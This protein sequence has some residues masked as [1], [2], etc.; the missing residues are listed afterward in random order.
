MF[1]GS[2]I[3]GIVQCGQIFLSAADLYQTTL[4]DWLNWR[5]GVCLTGVQPPMHAACACLQCCC[6]RLPCSPPAMIKRCV[7]RDGS[8]L[9]VLTTL[10]IFPACMTELMTQLEYLSIA[11]VPRKGL[12]SLMAVASTC[13]HAC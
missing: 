4:P 2:I 12:I 5:C 9:M 3:G 8:V 10:F 7:G 1:L 6:M 11:G 13:P